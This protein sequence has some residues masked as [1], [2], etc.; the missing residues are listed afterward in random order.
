MTSFVDE[1][2]QE[3]GVEPICAELPIA[4]STYW[5]HK[6]REREPERCSA[7]SRRDSELR[8]P[9]RVSRT[10]QYGS[11]I[12]LVDGGRL[13]VVSRLFGNEGGLGDPV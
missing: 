6:R 5:E 3:F 10:S 2:R 11:N 9:H 12:G 13:R 8:E 4:P 1:N 7:H